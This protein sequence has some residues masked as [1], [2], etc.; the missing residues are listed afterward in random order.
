MCGTFRPAFRE[1]SSKRIDGGSIDGGFPWPVT[2]GVRPGTRSNTP[3][4]RAS[5][6]DMLLFEFRDRPF[7]L[8][9]P[10]IRFCLLRLYK[11]L[12]YLQLAHPTSCKMQQEYCYSW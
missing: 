6:T 9:C 12:Y 7:M 4:A 8:D 2:L 11:R 1:T 10:L 3:I 5:T